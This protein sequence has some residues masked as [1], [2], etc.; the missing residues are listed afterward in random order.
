MQTNAIKKKKTTVPNTTKFNEML[1]LVKCS[2][3]EASSLS[4]VCE[5]GKPV[6]VAP[7]QDSLFDGMSKVDEIKKE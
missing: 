6:S 7:N 2:E 3:L 1:L 4:S 5:K